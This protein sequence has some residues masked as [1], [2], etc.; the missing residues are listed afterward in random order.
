MRLG[1]VEDDDLAL[2][3]TA[4]RVSMGVPALPLPQGVVERDLVY[5]C[6]YVCV[7]GGGQWLKD[8]HSWS[9]WA[10][11]S[12]PPSLLGLVTQ[13]IDPLIRLGLGSTGHLGHGTVAT[14]NSLLL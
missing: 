9:H 2:Y 8:L 1:K 13:P 7:W 6:V 11:E 3:Q 10:Q 4:P 5:V 12:L 14:V